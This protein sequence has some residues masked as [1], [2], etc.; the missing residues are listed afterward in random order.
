MITAVAHLL[1]LAVAAI[2]TGTAE[3]AG[4]MMTAEEVAGATMTAGA[5]EAVTV[6]RPQLATMTAE[7]RS[8]VWLHA[9]PLLP[10]H[11]DHEAPPGGTLSPTV[12]KACLLW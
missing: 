7:V 5:A 8:L 9:I 2:S 6:A 4:A 12:R 3:V 11:A 1:H 10:A